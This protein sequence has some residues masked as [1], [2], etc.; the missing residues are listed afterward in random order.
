MCTLLSWC[1]YIWNGSEE[2]LNHRITPMYLRGG[3]VQCNITFPIL[4]SINGS[5]ISPTVGD[6]T[7]IYI[8]FNSDI[9]NVLTILYKGK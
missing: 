2:T 3:G 5:L 7:I 9:L 4:R 6:T 8:H 1:L